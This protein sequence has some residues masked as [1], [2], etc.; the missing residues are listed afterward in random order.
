MSHAHAMSVL[1]VL[2]NAAVERL[3]P[4]VLIRGH[5][6]MY[7]WPSSQNLKLA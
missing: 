2:D 4:S 1:W 7:V 3:L 6:S 5:I